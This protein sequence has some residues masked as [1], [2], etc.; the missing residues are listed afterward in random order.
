[1]IELRNWLTGAM[2]TICALLD[3]FIT[4]AFRVIEAGPRRVVYLFLL[5]AFY[6]SLISCLWLPGD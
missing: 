3:M 1:M 6:A 4:L 2:G 5:F